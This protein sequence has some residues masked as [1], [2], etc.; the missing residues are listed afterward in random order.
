MS[1]LRIADD[2]CGWAAITAK[3]SVGVPNDA[4]LSWEFVNCMQDSACLTVHCQ[5]NGL[6]LPAMYNIRSQPYVWAHSRVLCI[7]WI[8]CD[9]TL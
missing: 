4:W 3:A 2:S 6:P 9:I 5:G 7:S 8:F 1:L